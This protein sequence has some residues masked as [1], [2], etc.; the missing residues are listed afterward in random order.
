MPIIIFLSISTILWPLI[1]VV[2][3]GP[4]KIMSA[5]ILTMIT[6]FISLNVVSSFYANISS[7]S[8]ILTINI[9]V[10][11]GYMVYLIV[12]KKSFNINDIKNRFKWITTFLIIISVATL[13]RIF[14]NHMNSDTILYSWI[15]QQ[16]ANGNFLSSD[17]EFYYRI[18]TFY[19]IGSISGDYSNYHT[20]FGEVTQLVL[21]TFVV[22][23]LLHQ[24]KPKSFIL[25][26]LCAVLLGVTI[27]YGMSFRTSSVNWSAGAI[28]MLF[29]LANRKNINLLFL[30]PLAFAN[31]SFSALL[32]LP[33]CMLYF[34]FR[35]KF[36]LKEIL[37]ASSLT[38]SIAIFMLFAF[39]DA[40]YKTFSI[41][42][43]LALINIAMNKTTKIPDYQIENFLY[44]IKIPWLVKFKESK[45]Y[46]KIMFIS[47]TSFLGF[48]ELIMI[49]MSTQIL[50]FPLIMN[51]KVGSILVIMPI[52]LFIL[53]SYW[54]DTDKFPEELQLILFMTTTMSAYFII[55]L[56]PMAPN[57][58]ADRISLPLTA[59]SP[60]IGVICLVRWI[61][62]ESALNI[63]NVKKGG[64]ILA[65][66]TSTLM[67]WGN[68]TPAVFWSP[69]TTQL[70]SNYKFVKN[71]EIQAI[72]E[73]MQTYNNSVIYSDVA[74]STI[75]NIDEDR[76]YFTHNER[77]FFYSAMKERM[78]GFE[79]QFMQQMKEYYMLLAQNNYDEKDSNFI[80]QY[81]AKLASGEIK[82]K[83][84]PYIELAK[85]IDVLKMDNGNWWTE[86]D[87]RN[88]I[89]ANPVTHK[90]VNIFAFREKSYAI[91][92]LN[93][94]NKTIYKNKHLIIQEINGMYVVK[95]P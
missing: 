4:K 77:D 40:P 69:F 6:L 67:M 16:T 17:I 70:E 44:K 53:V 32:F 56:I 35:R 75:N 7:I 63:I 24:Q 46:K 3:V 1:G 5:M 8:T 93:H 51:P 60:I 50:E 49:L 94:Y 37:I 13:F 73:I 61:N 47:F 43:P 76:I 41:I 58:L 79:T 2:L 22:N 36:T 80:K 90:K 65:T 85:S 66:G 26:M 83:V 74:I 15:S 21:C 27:V 88:I 81:K 86:W 31:F 48:V 30:T 68:T 29:I 45:N 87:K 55:Q 10:S 71:N 54:I 91:D 59:I 89:N 95:L 82:K 9:L 57:Y 72:K 25:S 39:V 34:F 23:Y 78:Q 42:V 62:E 11:I 92:V 20:I 33:I 12:K 19:Q 52:I 18:P 84:T 64:L 14:I 38:I 28:T